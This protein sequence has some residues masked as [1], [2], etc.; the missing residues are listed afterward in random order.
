MK[1]TILSVSLFVVLMTSCAKNKCADCHYDAPAG[2]I[3][4]GTYCGDELKNLEALGTYTDSL[5]NTYVV[6]CG[7]H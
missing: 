7:E 2:E 5:G 6:H 1:K 3:E 4:M